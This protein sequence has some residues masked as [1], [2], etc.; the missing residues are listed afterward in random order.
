MLSN[1]GEIDEVWL[2]GAKGEE[3]L[4]RVQEYD[5]EAFYKVIDQLQPR[6]V[7]AVMGNDVRWV[8]NEKGFARETE[9]SVTP[10]QPNIDVATIKE[11]ERLGISP[12]AED[13]GS[14]E[15]IVR[16]K[17]LYWYPAEVNVSLRPGWFYHP[18][19]DQ[20]IKTL[21]QLVDIY[22]KS[23]GRNA[24]LL[25]NVSPD[26]RGLLP[27]T[28]VKRL[29][30]FGNYIASTFDENKLVD[31]KVAWTTKQ[32]GFREYDLLENDTINTIM[33]QED[34]KQGQRVESFRVDA[35]MGNGWKK[36]GEGTTI[37]YKRLLKFNDVAT[38]KIRITILETRD[39]ANILNV[40]AFYA[41]PTEEYS[42]NK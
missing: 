16:A 39:E 24:V 2:D 31:G 14:R 27:E 11:N 19:E 28:D 36:L 22:Y 13:L 8:G 32:G 3:P 21:K 17:K 30:Q 29:E 37:G 4:E 26:T 23:V 33:L 20:Q 42:A 5:W 12:A 34:I 35:Q 10:L 25:L 15:L 18:E 1:Y 7:K 41:P 6:A 40:G 9:W 38:S